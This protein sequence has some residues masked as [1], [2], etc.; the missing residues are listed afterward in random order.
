MKETHYTW[1]K[2]KKKVDGVINNNIAYITP[3]SEN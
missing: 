2:K 1:L 3:C